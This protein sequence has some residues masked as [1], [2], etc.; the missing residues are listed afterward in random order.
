[1]RN[2]V[3][4]IRIAD[5]EIQNLKRETENNGLMEWWKCDG[6]NTWNLL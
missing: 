1:M 6:G 2:R 4:G 3:F 5:C